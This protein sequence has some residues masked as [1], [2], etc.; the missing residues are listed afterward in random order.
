MKRVCFQGRCS[1]SVM[2]SIWS[3]VVCRFFFLPLHG[4]L[5]YSYILF[6]VNVIKQ[7]VCFSTYEALLYQSNRSSFG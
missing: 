6:Q 7:S 2:G 4:H 5:I 1:L 3:I